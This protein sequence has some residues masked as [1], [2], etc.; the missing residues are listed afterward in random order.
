MS[1]IGAG[2]AEMPG[3]DEL[4]TN[5]LVALADAPH[6]LVAVTSPRGDTRRLD[7]AAALA[8]SAE[9]T[10]RRVALVNAD[11]SESRDGS[12]AP[13]STVTT[14]AAAA[15]ADRTPRCWWPR[16]FGICWPTPPTPT[17]WWWW[18]VRRSSTW[19]RR[20]PSPRR[21]PPP[22]SW[23][24]SAPRAGIPRCRPPR[25]SARPARSCSAWRCAAP[26]RSGAADRGRR[27]AAHPP[28]CARRPRV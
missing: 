28:A 17:T 13:A 18:R 6:P 1:K 14:T 23:L 8:A 24:H 12:A 9:Q 3:I 27:A 19:P 11:V 10:G 2:N 15:V 20:A 7:V 4:R 5:V 25:C 16:T 22:C 26:R 21:A